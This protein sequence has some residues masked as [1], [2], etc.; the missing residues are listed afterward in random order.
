MFSSPWGRLQRPRASQRLPPND[1]RSDDDANRERV[2]LLE[3]DERLEVA[4]RKRQSFLNKLQLEARRK[5]LSKGKVIS[6]FFPSVGAMNLTMEEVNRA[7]RVSGLRP[8]DV[9]GV[10]LNDFRTNQAEIMLANETEFDLD[11]DLMETKMKDANIHA[12][13]SVFDALEEV[14]ILYGL[15]FSSDIE[16]MKSMIVETISP[17][18][19]KVG[20]VFPCKYGATADE[21]FQGK[22]NGQWKVKVSPRA[23]RQ[24]PNFIVI[25]PDSRVMVKAKYVR[26]EFERKQMCSDCFST[27]HF[28]LHEDCQG[29]KKWED[30]CKEFSDHWEMCRLHTE[31]SEDQLISRSEEDSRHIVLS[32]QLQKDLEN[33]ENEKLLLE[34]RLKDQDE[35]LEKIKK[36]EEDNQRL[37]TLGNLMGCR[38]RSHSASVYSE[39]DR[40][41]E[42]VHVGVIHGSSSTRQISVD[43]T[44]G[45]G[46]RLESVTD[47]AFLS[48]SDNGSVGEDDELD[49]EYDHDYMRDPLNVTVVE[50]EDAVI[51]PLI[52]ATIA[53]KK[54]D[55][56]KEY[57]IVIDKQPGNNEDNCLYVLKERD[58]DRQVTVDLTTLDWS[59]VQK[60]KKRKC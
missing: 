9:V 30:Y 40:P 35:H 38:V 50:S 48:R 28:R 19:K 16:G 58:S 59:P 7:L 22:Y 33:M 34:T 6:I 10:K 20:N 5:Q 43:D 52:D 31:E 17:F 21:F 57:C 41:G 29:P 44:V 23:D 55:G 39:H 25:G 54:P 42:Y 45:I 36:L 56:N 13:V 3:R 4:E 27:G 18:V 15:P 53:I 32:R 60:V 2:L 8:S 11:I 49:L 37:R 12:I 47:P 1:N 14:L 26:N 24:V 46:S 51:D